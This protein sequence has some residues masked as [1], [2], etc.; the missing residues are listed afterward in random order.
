MI[1]KTVSVLNKFFKYCN[2][3]IDVLKSSL[4]SSI[5]A[6]LTMKLIQKFGTHVL[7]VNKNPFMLI[8]HLLFK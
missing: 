6:V 8:K 1:Q 4:L 5:V 3:Y 7:N 2:L